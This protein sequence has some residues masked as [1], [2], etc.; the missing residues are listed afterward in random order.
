MSRVLVTVSAYVPQGS[1]SAPPPALAPTAASSADG[2]DDGGDDAAQDAKGEMMGLGSREDAGMEH[3]A[4]VDEGDQPNAYLPDPFD[5]GL[6]CLECEPAP[7]PPPDVS[8]VATPADTATRPSPTPASAD[9]PSSPAS[10]TPAASSGNADLPDG[11]AR[12]PARPRPDRAFFWEPSADAHDGSERG[13]REEKERKQQQEEGEDGGGGVAGNEG[14]GDGGMPPVPGFLPMVVGADGQPVAGIPLAPFLP[15]DGG[16]GGAAQAAMEDGSRGGIRRKVTVPVW[17]RS[18]SAG[19][20][21]V[22]AKV[23]Y[24]LG[25]GG[26]VRSGDGLEEGAEQARGVATG[27]ARAEVL[28]VRPL[29]AAVDV[30]AIQVCPRFLLCFH[31][32]CVGLLTS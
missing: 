31:T 6:L 4:R 26:G 18:E 25:R 19:T 11:P 17:V 24:G 14:K 32:D 7:V 5:E 23:V 30:V 3:G 2:G 16:S 15:Q 20:V 29:A 21:V 22:R 8:T 12:F 27:W 1:K 28:C 13:T 9:P 10:G